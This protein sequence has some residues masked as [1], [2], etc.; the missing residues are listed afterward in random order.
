MKKLS[1]YPVFLILLGFALLFSTGCSR[2]SGCA[3]LMKTTKV[4][5]KKAGGSRDLFGHRM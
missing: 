1:V 5:K 2:K 3:A 4:P